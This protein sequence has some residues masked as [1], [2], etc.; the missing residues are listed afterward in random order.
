M[1]YA[2]IAGPT[3][4]GK[5]DFAIEIALALRT[6]IVGADAFQIYAGLD[7]L[8]GKPSL[9]QLRQVHHHLIGD[10]PLTE[11]CDAHHYV[12]LARKNIAELNQRS[13]VPL[14][15]GGTGF[16][17]E[18]LEQELPDLPAADPYLRKELELLATDDLLQQLH[19][20]DP[21]CWSRIDRSNRRR[22]IR[23]LEVCLIT[24]RP[25]SSFRRNSA[26]KATI[27]AKVALERPREELYARIDERV[28]KMFANGVVDE[29]AAVTN[30]SATAEQMIGLRQI[31][32]LLAGKIDEPA[33]IHRIQQLTRNY[34]KRQMTWFRNRGYERTDIR[35]NHA[36]FIED[37]R[38]QVARFTAGHLA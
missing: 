7:L 19:Q 11:W 28:V 35:A 2:V 33:C 24:G 15:V 31:R 9:A 27:I 25:F 4:V 36:S 3:G 37:V 20:R 18:A 23:A 10:L 38:E 8:S 32:S 21:A 14:V 22:I 16:Y 29:V 30:I 34:A 1:Q 13:I 12:A 17:L 26:K 5:S 6:E